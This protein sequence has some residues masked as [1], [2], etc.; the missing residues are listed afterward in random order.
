[1]LDRVLGLSLSWLPILGA[2][3]VGYAGLLLWL[4]ARRAEMDEAADR[5]SPV[6]RARYD[7]LQRRIEEAGSDR[8][9]PDKAGHAAAV[10]GVS[11]VDYRDLVELEKTPWYQ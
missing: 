9:D 6:D 8:F 4:A 1:M 10:C 11:L 2:A 3:Q 7:E 5:L